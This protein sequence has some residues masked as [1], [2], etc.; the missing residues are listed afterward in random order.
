[1]RGDFFNIIILTLLFALFTHSIWW[2]DGVGIYKATSKQGIDLIIAAIGSAAGAFGGAYIVEKIQRQKILF[3]ELRNTNAAIMIAAHILSQS[4]NRK[5]N[6]ILPLVEQFSAEEEIFKVSLKNRSS[7]YFN[8]DLYSFESFEYDTDIL[9]EILFQRLSLDPRPL[10]AFGELRTFLNLLRSA[11]NRRNQILDE[12]KSKF[13]KEDPNSG[14]EIMRRYFG[15]LELG[16][17]DLSYSTNL[18]AL[19]AY[20]DDC[21]FFSELL[22]KDLMKH[23]IKLSNQISVTSIKPVS[24]YTNEIPSLL[25][26]NRVDHAKWLSQFINSVAS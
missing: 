14:F 3:E 5:K 25:R 1:M 15:A 18:T 24:V 21:I 7:Y 16:A 20:V 11:I 26:P 10:A 23:A 6:D 22:V 8:P 19:H 4:V 12:W 2:A 13:P 9:A 17:T